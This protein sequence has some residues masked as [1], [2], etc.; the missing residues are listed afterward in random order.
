MQT[1]FTVFYGDSLS[2]ELPTSYEY[3]IHKVE[4]EIDSKEASF[5]SLDDYTIEIE[6]ESTSLD[7]IGDYEIEITLTDA[8][9]ETSGPHTIWI[10]IADPD[11]SRKK[12]DKGQ[13]ENSDDEI[14]VDQDNEENKEEYQED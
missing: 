8:D 10:S 7:D 4:A 2:Y 11:E 1:E 14:E 5:V 6:A 9:D 13:V 12:R 3:K